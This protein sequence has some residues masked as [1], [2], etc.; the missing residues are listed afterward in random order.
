MYFIKDD[1]HK[2][3]KYFIANSTVK[4]I[5]VIDDIIFNYNKSLN[6][7]IGIEPINVNTFIENEIIQE[8]KT[9]TGII[10]Q[11]EPEFIVGDSVILKN[12]TVLFEDK[13]KPAYGNKIYTVTGITANSLKLVDDENNVKTVKKSQAKK[14]DVNDF[15]VINNRIDNVMNQV[16]KENK[17]Q[18][19][20][21]K[22]GVD[23]NNI[24]E[25]RRERKATTRYV[26]TI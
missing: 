25:G 2:L 11:A 26:N 20:I 12:K 24:T 6:R 3:T 14:I 9:Q 18:R 10:K 16:N 5:D 21:R 17:Q 13:M 8:K 4:W 7:G 23:V 19:Q 22:L 1:S 15:I